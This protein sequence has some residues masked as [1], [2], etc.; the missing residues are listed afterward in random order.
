MSELVLPGTN[1]PSLDA[2]AASVLHEV[3]T[4]FR[5][6]TSPCVNEQAAKAGVEKL[7]RLLAHRLGDHELD[8]V[9]A[10][11]L[12][13]L[14]RWFSGG[15]LVKL[16]DRYEPFAKFL[17]R[18]TAPSKYAQLQAEAGNRLSAAK[19]L[20][21]LG[22]V[23]NK[24]MSA[25]ESCSWEQF[26]PP[27]VQGKPH[28]IEHIARTYV[29]RNV[30][31]HQARVLNQ[32]EKAQV[33]ESICVFLVW[34][35]IK[36]DKE[37]SDALT[38]AW[39]SSYLENLRDRFAEIG[40][41][42]V[43]LITEARSPEEYRL[44]D[45]LSPV[46]E[47]AAIGALAD[48]ASLPD[49]NR[50]T[51]IEAE[52]G[53]GKTTT[54]K[55]LAWR[56]AD[57]LLA[58]KPGC[59]HV[60]VYIELKLLPPRS[61]T[62]EDA[63]QQALNPGGEHT[64]PIP[65]DSLLLLV[66]GLN[67][68]DPQSQMN[69]KAEIRH[70]LSQFQKLRIVVAGR[71][72]SFSGE[73]EGSV[74]VLRRLNDQQL[75]TLF[76][77]ALRDDGKAAAL[78]DSL[79]AN[80]F[81]SS[82]ARTPLNAALITSLAQ[83]EGVEALANQAMAVRR[84]IRQFLSRE[85]IQSPHQT[86]LLKKE[87]LLSLLAFETK[88][89]RQLA[90]TKTS[91]LSILGAAKAKLGAITL[92]LPEFVHEI[93]NN[94]L[95]QDS[96]G[97]LLQF[98]H[99]VYHDYLA[100]CEL[101][102]REHMQP[103][104]GTEFA[105]A[106]F[107]E[108]HWQDCVRLYA[109]LTGCAA[110]L[111]ERGADK[112]P[113]L[114]WLLLREAP[115]AAPNLREAVALAAYSALEGDLRLTGNPA[116]AGACVPVLADLGRADLLEQA[117]IRQQRVLEPTGMWKLSDQERQAEAK[118]IQEALVPLGHGLLS[119]LRLGALEQRA[120]KEGRFCEASRAAIRALKQIKAAHALVVILASWTGNTFAPASLI[121]STI[122][123]ALIDLGV[124]KVLDNEVERH[125]KVLLEWL[126][127]ASEASF[128]HAWPA[129]GR[130]LRLA[131]HYYELG[132]DYEPEKALLW[133]RKAH[134]A[135]SETGS[136]DLALLLLDEPQLAA[137]PLEGDRLINSLAAKGN[138]EAT[139]AIA[140]RSCSKN[141]PNGKPK[142]FELLLALATDGHEKARRKVL[143]YCYSWLLLDPEPHE[144]MPPWAVPFKDR[145]NAVRK[146]RRPRRN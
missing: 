51:V 97:E 37:I 76:R 50:V 84:F 137:D 17:L 123:E 98:A 55:F 126:A 144:E 94:H 141:D 122:L 119:V 47:T 131:K 121:P 67:E 109:G 85:A 96:G 44:L 24:A 124:E 42:S 134:D 111:I 45:P 16:A 87:R 79:R 59:S 83:R 29:F 95:L 58:E 143:E 103:G 36:F 7:F 32:R 69:F 78:F 91:T 115:T 114:A 65:W 33:A 74:V 73:F 1:D 140:D 28:F 60:P 49:T 12:A 110:G 14:R 61:Q 81:L 68:V 41:R 54:L 116:L 19:V 46:P 30:E 138:K 105:I 142:G 6:S 128:K 27:D 64:T 39:F 22:L 104:L 107:A 18:L 135:G 23:N 35:A 40:T 72:N 90:F 88:S 4:P 125:N 9:G 100:A 113:T 133:L 56:Q 66:D 62:I 112:N 48:A 75:I 136:L 77:H 139:Y 31:D 52:P 71:P 5:A 26:P 80:P 92:D 8:S 146:Q 20:K 13:G 130:A 145:I 2:L 102:T 57:A 38:R 118:R 89:A 82:W 10:E 43:A 11:I 63:V 93:L 127:R 132:F 21:A 70:L 120:G 108:P 25:F 99:E 129:Y 101:E 106:H 34:C 53:A 86:L 15:E 117:I 3:A